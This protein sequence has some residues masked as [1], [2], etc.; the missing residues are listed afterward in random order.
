MTNFMLHF[1]FQS[2]PASYH[3]SPRLHRVS[4]GPST[5]S[6]RPTYHTQPGSSYQQNGAGNGVCKDNIKSAK[7]QNCHVWTF[8][9]IILKAEVNIFEQI[10]FQK[11]PFT[12]SQLQYK[13]NRIPIQNAST[14]LKHLQQKTGFSR[15]KR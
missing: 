9:K 11:H 13:S 3:R 8:K 4:P 12:G 6:A 15:E 7:T 2:T 5:G 1:T 10:L 14:L